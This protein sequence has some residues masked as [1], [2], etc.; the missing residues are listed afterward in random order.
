MAI[1]Y[2]AIDLH[3]DNGYCAILD[4]D[5]RRVFGKRLHND[6]EEVAASLG[7]YRDELVGIAVESTYNWYWLVDGLQARGYRVHLVNTAGV[8]QYEGLKYSDDRRDALFLANLL[9]L[10][11]LPEGYIYPKEERGVRDLLRKR[12]LLVR[13]RTTH[14][15]SLENLIARNTGTQISARVATRMNEEDVA[16]MIADPHV[17]MSAQMNIEA[18]RFFSERIRVVEKAVLAEQQL[19]DDH[20]HLLTVPGIG[21]IM[22]MT[23]ALETGDIG[24]FPGAG[25]YGSYSRCV[26]SERK[27]NEKPKGK[28]NEKCGNR[29]LGWAYVEVAHFMLRS[30]PPAKS[31][32]Q[33]KANKRNTTVATK[34]L[35]NKIARACYYIMRDHTSFDGVRMFGPAAGCGGEPVEG[36]AKADR[37]V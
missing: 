30:Y 24:R 16:G 3:G 22:A 35:A 20:Q 26:K 34:A 37:Q 11:I 18:I 19:E 29:Y 14:I 32:Y 10:Q 2:G 1:L 23:I 17:R 21:P 12:M 25:N 28:G 7:P 31:F 27:S 13:Q 36:L 8:Q 9:R 15:L 33:R 6:I 5:Q 4:Q